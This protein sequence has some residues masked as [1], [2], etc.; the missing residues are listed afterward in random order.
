MEAWK[1]VNQLAPIFSNPQA[2]D[3]VLRQ[4]IS[5]IVGSGGFSIY[6]PETLKRLWYLRL[7]SSLSKNSANLYRYLPL[8]GANLGVLPPLITGFSPNDIPNTSDWG[9]APCDQGINLSGCP[10]WVLGRFMAVAREQ[11]PYSDR[12][13]IA[14]H[15]NFQIVGQHREK[16]RSLYYDLTT[17]ANHQPRGRLAGCAFVAVL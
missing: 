5:E 13:W 8:V 4:Q 12:H 15:R 1:R 2:C 3:R 14:Q 11:C 17:L 10:H 16:F 7:I 6:G 9:W